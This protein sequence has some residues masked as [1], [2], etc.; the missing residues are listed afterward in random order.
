M[1]QWLAAVMAMGVVACT[2]HLDTRPNGTSDRAAVGVPYA[3]PVVHHDLT[4]SRTLVGLGVLF[5]W[6]VEHRV[7]RVTGP[8]QS[9]KGRLSSRPSRERSTDDVLPAIRP[10]TMQQRRP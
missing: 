10:L 5:A 8:C 7:T 3:L 1:K 9:D 4:V 6:V 2:T